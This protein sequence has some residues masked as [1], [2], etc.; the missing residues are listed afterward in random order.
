MQPMIGKEAVLLLLNH[1]IGSL[2]N[3]LRL[4]NSDRKCIESTIRCLEEIKNQLDFIVPVVL[5]GKEVVEVPTPK[6]P[7]QIVS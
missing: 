1:R 4:G 3:D 6:V 2:R 5:A 7:L